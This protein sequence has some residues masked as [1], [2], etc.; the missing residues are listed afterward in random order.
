MF[1]AVTMEV[2]GLKAKVKKAK[3]EVAKLKKAKEEAAEQKATAERSLAEL[4]TMKSVSEKHEA[5]VP[6]CSKSSRMPSIMWGLDTSP[7]YL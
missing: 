3:E 5:R 2:E 7:T 4:M 1:A 6:K